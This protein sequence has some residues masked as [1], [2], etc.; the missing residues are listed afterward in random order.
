MNNMFNQGKTITTKMGVEVPL[1]IFTSVMIP[2][3]KLVK[4]EDMKIY[5]HEGKG[6]YVGSCVIV[7]SDNLENAEGLIRQSLDNMGLSDEELSIT[8]KEIS[9]G[10]IV[11]N[12]SGDY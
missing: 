2:K 3:E 6:H 4:K 5:I 10:I 11:W 1:E 9:N 7:V 12:E 8:E